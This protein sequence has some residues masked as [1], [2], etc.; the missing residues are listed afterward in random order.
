MDTDFSKRS[1]D[2]IL[3]ARSEAI[4]FKSLDITPEHLFLGIIKTDD[5]TRNILFDLGI[6]VNEL[7]SIISTSLEGHQNNKG[8]KDIALSKSA[9]K[10]IKLVSLE[11]Q[12]LKQ[13]LIEPYHLLLSILREPHNLIHQELERLGLVDGIRK[14]IGFRV[15]SGLLKS[16]K[17]FLRKWF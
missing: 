14:E 2:A 11:A 8:N 7:I 12:I 10:I 15:D 13:D 17:G 5:Q 1:K 9:D 6:N 4:R 3:H 16:K